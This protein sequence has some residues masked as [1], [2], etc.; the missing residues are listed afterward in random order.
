MPGGVP[1]ENFKGTAL[2]LCQG[3]CSREGALAQEQ[4]GIAGE[5]FEGCSKEGWGQRSR[6]RV[7][8]SGHPRKVEGPVCWEAARHSLTEGWGLSGLVSLLVAESEH[9]GWIGQGL[10][11]VLESSWM[12]L[13]GRGG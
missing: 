7:G 6:C 9:R 13:E 10:V 8:S 2:G 11:G 1:K 5:E 3:R 4:K 12:A